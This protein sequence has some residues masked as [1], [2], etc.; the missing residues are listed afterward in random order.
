MSK[1]VSVTCA[2][3][4]NGA[5]K[6]IEKRL[7]GR[8]ARRGEHEKVTPC[9]I[10][11]RY[12]IA[13][14]RSATYS[15]SR[16]G[17]LELPKFCSSL[18]RLRCYSAVNCDSFKRG[19]LILAIPDDIKIAFRRLAAAPMFSTVAVLSLALGI[20][21]ISALFLVMNALM[22][23]QLPVSMPSQLV[24]VRRSDGINL[25]R[26][27]VWREL[28][29]RQT[30]FSSTAAF[31]EVSFALAS[32]GEKL[33]LPG[34]FV[35]D[36]YFD[37]LGIRPVRGRAFTSVDDQPN[38]LPVCIISYSFWE[39]QYQKSESV[40]GRTLGLDGREFEIVGVAP[41]GFFGTE[42]GNNFQIVVPIAMESKLHPI[43]SAWHDLLTRVS[44]I[45]RLK[46]G[47]STEQADA[48][49]RAI[50]PSIIRDTIPSDADDARRQAMLNTNFIVRPMSNGVTS[51]LRYRY[52]SAVTLMFWM[53]FALL[54]IACINLA[55]L[56]LARSA[57]RK[58]EFATRIALGATR[59]R[60]ARQLLTEAFVLAFLGT[61][62]GLLISAF[63]SRA[64]IVA[65]SST[66]DRH[67]LDLSFDWRAVTFSAAVSFFCVMIVGVVP[68]LRAV[69]TPT[70][71]PMNSGR[72]PA[73][74]N[75]FTGGSFSIAA[76]ISL[77]M[78]LV[79]SAFLLIRT[80]EKLSSVNPGFDAH[81]VLTVSAEVPRE[82][83]DWRRD[84]VIA[85]ALGNALRESRGVVSIGRTK[86]TVDTALQV[87]SIP[88]TSGRERK[89]RS[90]V[91]HVDPAYFET[92]RIPIRA[93]RKFGEQDSKSSP[94]VAILSSTGASVLF[95]SSAPI[96]SNFRLLG[97]K[98]NESVEVVGVAGDAQYGKPKDPMINVIYRPISQCAE[99]CS[100]VGNYY[101]RYEGSLS[102][103]KSAVTKTARQLDP[104]LSLETG[105]LEDENRSLLQREHLT[106]WLA[107]IAG[108][109]ALV[110][111][112]IGI[113]GITALKTQQRR[114]D[115]G[116][117]VALGAQRRHV[118][119][120]VLIPLA[121]AS[122]IGVI[123]GSWMAFGST[124]LFQESMY[125]VEAA[126]PLVYAFAA[127]FLLIVAFIAGA[128]PIEKALRSNPI[129][130]LRVD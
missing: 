96:T 48:E 120:S 108:G 15:A 124:R 20:G 80:I 106:A 50:S 79:V 56:L 34:L 25:H 5:R 99:A 22:F 63:A 43:G 53:A 71:S 103:V 61:A 24:E 62:L 39:N 70:L 86:R 114:K 73:P 47:I 10:R 19:R 111:A 89:I 7:G 82:T 117:R 125:G 38:A 54:L 113:Y 115:I 58:S 8:G 4:R 88:S 11:I 93:G 32:D 9:G 97:S 104:H 55:N 49:I 65:I 21:A 85:G 12:D 121:I 127:I 29:E 17:R 40:L 118:I 101:L 69:H 75:G 57:S 107:S 74:R 41:E 110:I 77:S 95:D 51:S 112:S 66:T 42:V 100:G 128:I 109:F 27:L 126:T 129:T 81:N 119:Q 44:I 87:V 30:V 52:S 3:A 37:T 98:T 14:S 60:L 90:Y 6:P 92:L 18:H 31:G 28:R 46:P 105:L 45:G 2:L 68:A 33:S 91:L 64:L 83:P 1:G 122:V 35:S 76:Q 59:W 16:I 26:N 13:C 23:K 116:I 72:S 84:E 67:F 102:Q 36:S 94:A 78:V 123:L 130:E